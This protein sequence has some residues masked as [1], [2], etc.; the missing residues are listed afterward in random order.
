MAA[1]GRRGRRAER[2]GRAA[3]PARCP[4]WPAPAS[5]CGCRRPMP[6]PSKGAQLA[7][8][9]QLSSCTAPAWRSGASAA[10]LRGPSGSGKSDL[11][12]ALPVPGPAR[13]GGPGSR[14][15]WSPTIRCGCV[16]DGRPPAGRGAARHHARQDGGARRRHRRGQVRWPRPSWRWSST[17]WP[18]AR[19]NGCR[20]RDAR[21]RLLGRRRA[22]HRGCAPW[23]ASAPIKLAL[24]LARAEADLI[25]TV[26]EQPPLSPCLDGAA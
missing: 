15:P 13:P 3:G 16:R 25:R 21:A 1:A 23:E 5:R 14:R 12:L 26:I 10:L 22:A 19:W 7:W 8:P 24:A 18:P 17:W 4:A 20:T 6:Q 9:T 2:A 11:A